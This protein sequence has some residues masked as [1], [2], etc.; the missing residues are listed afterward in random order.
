[1]WWIVFLFT[2]ICFPSPG[3]DFT[4]LL[5]VRFGHVHR[6]SRSDIYQ[7]GDKALKISLCFIIP[8]FSSATVTDSVL[9]RG[10]SISLDLRV[11]MTWSIG[12]TCF[13]NEK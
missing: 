3:E 12:W 11:K 9:D 4:S 13:M 5:E 8:S 1:M 10:C 7:F 2:E 6:M